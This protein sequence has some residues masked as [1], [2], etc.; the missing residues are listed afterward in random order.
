[1]MN[2]IVQLWELHP[3]LTPE[4]TLASLEQAQVRFMEVYS[5]FHII[6][7]LI[8]VGFQSNL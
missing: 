6:I 4:D 1:M 8:Y 2:N 3:Y 7:V 5:F